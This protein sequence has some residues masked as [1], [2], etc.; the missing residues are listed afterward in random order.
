MQ[1]GA[2]DNIEA[3]CTHAKV[4]TAKHPVARRIEASA[5]P[6]RIAHCYRATTAYQAPV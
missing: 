6:S 4:S 1:L 3:R 5:L 2:R